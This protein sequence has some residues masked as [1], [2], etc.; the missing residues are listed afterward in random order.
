MKLYRCIHV[1]ATVFQKKKVS[2]EKIGGVKADQINHSATTLQFTAA[3][4]VH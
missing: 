2:Q 3:S 4:E 1:N